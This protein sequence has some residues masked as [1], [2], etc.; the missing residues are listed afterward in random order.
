MKKHIGTLFL[1]LVFLAGLG[2][3]LYP[4]VSDYVNSLHQS[5]A[6][7]TYAESVEKMDKTQYQEILETARRYNT[8]M[9][10]RTQNFVLTDSEAAQYAQL[11]NV[12]GNGA[13]GYIEIPSINVSLPIFHGTEELV[14]Q[15]AIGHLEWS[16]LPVGGESS[17]CV[18]SGHRG[19]PSAKLFTNLDKLAKGDTF[20]LRVLDEVLTYEVDQILIVEPK[21]TEALQIVQG[22]DYCTL[23][24]CSWDAL[25]TMLKG[26]VWA[27]SLVPDVEG[28][29]DA[30][31][32]MTVELKPGLYLVVGYRRTIGEY[33]YSAS[34][35]L[36]FLP[37]SNL[38]QNVWNHVV[39]S[40]PKSSPEKNPSDNPDDRLVSRR[41]LK[42]WDDSGKESGRPQEIT[43]HLLCDGKIFNTVTL[44]ADN[45]WRH[46]WD[47]LERNHDWLVTEDTVSGYTQAITQEGITFTVKNTVKP[48][49]PADPPKPPKPNLPQ[50]GLL[51][52]PV[53]TLFAGGLV[54][55]VIGL[56][57]RKGDNRA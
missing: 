47:N 4:T 54:F 23:V 29:T 14:L 53:L 30:D 31:G 34:P 39:T 46:A 33:T 3:L 11:L 32:K 16:S 40:C 36:V 15:T 41:V 35:Y 19:L 1:V 45:N 17:H 21:D 24:T 27:D 55:V 52:W 8:A 37:G 7:S 2:L 25:A 6:I 51:W 18:L 20:V 10:H 22:Q 26:Y 44:N 12:G 28:E 43:V 49:V 13:M 38:E 50:T 48:T 9:A 42:I 5:K 56:I 57:R